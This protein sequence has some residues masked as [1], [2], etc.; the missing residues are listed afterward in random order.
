[1]KVAAYCVALNEEKHVERWVE[2]TAGAD[3]RLVCDTGSRRN[4]RKIT[5]IRR[6]SI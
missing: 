3:Y 6:N 4:C 2:T 5:L 1:M